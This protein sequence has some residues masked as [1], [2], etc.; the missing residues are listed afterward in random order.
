MSIRI[1]F[2]GFPC[3]LVELI[4]YSLSV[5]RP[6]NYMLLDNR[7]NR[8]A[9]K[10]SRYHDIGKLSVNAAHHRKATMALAIWLRYCGEKALTTCLNYFIA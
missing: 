10:V 6:C 1:I 7:Q 3:W 9:N 2:I 4:G 5:T 8:N